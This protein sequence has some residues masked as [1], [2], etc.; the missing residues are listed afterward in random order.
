MI[1]SVALRQLRPAILQPAFRSAA[2]PQMVNSQV[3]LG[4]ARRW[5]TQ[6]QKGGKA[7]LVSFIEILIISSIFKIRFKKTEW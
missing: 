1:Q 6:E 7:K 4:M 3:G 5:N 2:R